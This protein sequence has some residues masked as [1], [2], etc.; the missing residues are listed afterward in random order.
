MN[1]IPTYLRGRKT[2]TLGITLICYLIVQ[3][4]NGDQ[5]DAIVVDA[6]LAAM[7]LTIRAGIATE[8]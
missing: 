1:T 3:A 6:M 5:P 4:I 7:G 8:K 2:Y